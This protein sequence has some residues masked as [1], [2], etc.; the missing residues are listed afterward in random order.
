MKSSLIQC[1]FDEKSR[2]A[3]CKDLARKLE[4]MKRQHRDF[5]RGDEFQISKVNIPKCILQAMVKPVTLC[6]I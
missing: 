2:N 1:S 5:G 6:K 3:H 4:G